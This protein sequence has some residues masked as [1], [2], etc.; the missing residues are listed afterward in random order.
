ML[1]KALKFTSPWTSFTWVD[2]QAMQPIAQHCYKH[3]HGPLHEQYF[4]TRKKCIHQTFL[5]RFLPQK[6][7][8]VHLEAGFEGR[9]FSK[10][11][12]NPWALQQPGRPHW[13]YR[14]LSTLKPLMNAHVRASKRFPSAQQLMFYKARRR[15]YFT[16]PQAALD[17]ELGLPS[18]A[19]HIG[20]E[21][22]LCISPH[23]LL[24]GTSR[25]ICLISTSKNEHRSE[26]LCYFSPNSTSVI[27][28]WE[29]AASHQT[30]RPG[31]L[32]SREPWAAAPKGKGSD[33]DV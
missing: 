2:L 20:I 15:F 8:R 27:S 6:H 12:T 4:S 23:T 21:L 24:C 22:P 29:I 30:A 11:N 33:T 5:P 9:L 25:Q 10:N 7:L 1:T 13:P 17:P 26:E 32:W 19:S 31:A 16:Q 3:A 18:L 28:R 14:V